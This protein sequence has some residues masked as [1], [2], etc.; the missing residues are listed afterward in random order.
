MKEIYILKL[1]KKIEEIEYDKVLLLLLCI[2]F[3]FVFYGKTIAVENVNYAVEQLHQYNNELFANNIGLLKDGIS[4][5]YYANVVVS[6][7]MNLFKLGWA[8][9]ITLIIRI[10]YIIYAVAVTRTVCN[11]TK[12]R[13]LLYGVILISCVFRSSLGILAGFGLNGAMDVFIGTGT[14]LALLAISF[15]VGQKKRWIPAWICIALATLMH[16]HE[17][18]WGGCTIGV[19]WLAEV[20]ANKKIDWKALRGLPVYMVV[21]LLVTVPS[22]LTD[23]TVDARTFAEIYVNI[24]TPNHLLPTAWGIGTSIKC[25]LMILLPVIY[26]VIYLKKEKTDE[27]TGRYFWLSIL[28]VT[29]WIVAYAIQYI[30]TVVCPNTTII[31]MYLPKLF[32]YITYIAMIL[33]LKFAERLYQKKYY[34]EAACALLIL[35]LG[36]DYNFGVTLILSVLLLV[37]E[38]WGEDKFIKKNIASYDSTIRLI[39]WEAFIGAIGLLHGWNPVVLTIVAIVFAVE[40]FMPYMN[41]KKISKIVLSLTAA[42]TIVFSIQGTI[43][44]VDESGISYVSGDECLRSAMGN[45]IYQMAQAFQTVSD[46]EEE[47]L[48]DPY[49]GDS[50]WVQLVSERNCYCIYKSTPSSKKAVIDWYARIQ[51]VENMSQLTAKELVQLM[52][53]IDIRYV[54]VTPEQYSDIETSGLF[55]T[56]VRTDTAAIYCIS[57]QEVSR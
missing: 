29:G 28:L 11:I 54:M 56:V 8:G 26:L 32:K 38:I 37:F 51:Q 5:R 1:R 35:I 39:T 10:N 18:M 15:I 16:V 21:M 13:R 30:A 24:R 4:P 34:I 36:T 14:A 23:D 20:I 52:Q 40:F 46:P 9:V 31:T 47:F 6:V 7:L 57:R 49:S 43:L 2:G 44:K 19:I 33:Y 42:F 22:L 41:H 55:E 17:G 3:S 53:K 25:F 50:G 12:E 48:A 45:D 27:N